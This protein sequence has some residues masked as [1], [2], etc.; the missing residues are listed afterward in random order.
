MNTENDW[1][2]C[3]TVEQLNKIWKPGSKVSRGTTSIRFRDEELTLGP[4]TDSGTF[5]FFTAAINGEEGASRTDYN[6]SENDNVTVQAVCGDKGGLGYFG[7][8]YAEQN[9]GSSRCPRWTAATV[10][11]S[12]PAR[13]FRTATIRPLS[14]PLFVYAKTEALELPEVEAFLQFMLDNQTEI[15]GRPVRS[16]HRRPAREG[17]RASSSQA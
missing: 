15:A 9:G 2:T 10:V 1:A 12:R 3:L 8:S 6:A 7:L 5:D 17:T 16:A 11:S 4:G 13:P 14:R